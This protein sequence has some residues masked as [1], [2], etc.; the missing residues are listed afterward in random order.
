MSSINSHFLENIRLKLAHNWEGNHQINKRPDSRPKRPQP[1]DLLSFASILD[2]I[3]GRGSIVRIVSE[4]IK[5]IRLEVDLALGVELPDLA[6]GVDGLRAAA[7]TARDSWKGINCTCNC[8]GHV[9]VYRWSEPTVMPL[10]YS[11]TSSLTYFVWG[12]ITLQLPSLFYLI[13]FS[14]FYHV[15]KKMGQPRPLFHLFSDFSN[16][17][18]YNFYNK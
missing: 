7:S 1:S 6:G 5:M 13:G 12:S 14:C 17:H 18:C 2:V 4:W 16:K 10:S 15:F 11:G 3:S 9:T 8:P